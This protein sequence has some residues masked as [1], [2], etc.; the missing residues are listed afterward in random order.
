[1][2]ALKAMGENME[3]VRQRHSFRLEKNKDGSFTFYQVTLKEIGWV[4]NEETWTVVDPEPMREQ[5]R[6]RG[7]IMNK[8]THAMGNVEE[9]WDDPVT[10]EIRR[11]K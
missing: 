3:K 4:E 9:F 2:P 7:Y 8:P 1:M 10:I 5:L 6:S 11:K